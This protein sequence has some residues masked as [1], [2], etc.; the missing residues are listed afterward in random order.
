MDT[1]VTELHHDNGLKSLAY[2]VLNAS[3]QRTHRIVVIC[4]SHEEDLNVPPCYAERDALSS[5]WLQVA[6]YQYMLVRFHHI[7]AWTTSSLTHSV[8]ILT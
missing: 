5:S 6:V 3:S 8:C 2:N 7:P 1:R 4:T